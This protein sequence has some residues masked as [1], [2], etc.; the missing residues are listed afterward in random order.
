MSG[1]WQLRVWLL[2]LGVALLVGAGVFC[3]GTDGMDWYCVIWLGTVQAVEKFELHASAK[4]VVLMTG[5]GNAI[6][7]CL[8]ARSL[9]VDY[10]ARDT[11]HDSRNW[12]TTA[13][14]GVL[15]DADID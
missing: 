5:S 7:G 4:S 3:L 8:T 15:D 11:L 13:A 1:W 10:V 14:D 12:S 6:L 2:L 9:R